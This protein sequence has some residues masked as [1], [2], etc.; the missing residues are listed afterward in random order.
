M[1]HKVLSCNDSVYNLMFL[2]LHLN[3]AL[4]NIKLTVKFMLIILKVDLY[5]E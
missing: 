4:Y 5:S 1:N 2:H 3:L